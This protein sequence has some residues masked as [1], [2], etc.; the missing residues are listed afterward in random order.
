V[1]RIGHDR[2]SP[3]PVSFQNNSVATEKTAGFKS[4][5]AIDEVEDL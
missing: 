3:S 1:K 2:S 5:R 4:T